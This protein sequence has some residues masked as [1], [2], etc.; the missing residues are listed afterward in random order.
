MI[1]NKS[2]IVKISTYDPGVVKS[3]IYLILLNDL[4]MHLISGERNFGQGHGKK[5]QWSDNLLTA[6]LLTIIVWWKHPR[7]Y[8]YI[9]M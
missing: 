4:P 5:T 7:R 6:S 3:T 9:S 8:K 1:S 2:H